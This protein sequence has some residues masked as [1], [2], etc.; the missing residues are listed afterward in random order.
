MLMCFLGWQAAA[1]V[2][3]DGLTVEINLQMACET[4]YS[5]AVSQAPWSS[6]TGRMSSLA[7]RK[8]KPGILGL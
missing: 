3:S 7:S 1:N 8:R 5:R 4:S 6:V 2:D